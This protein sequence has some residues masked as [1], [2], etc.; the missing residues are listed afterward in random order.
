MTIKEEVCRELI[1]FKGGAI[2]QC[3]DLTLSKVGKVLDEEIKEVEQYKDEM[4]D[5]ENLTYKAM[6]IREIITNLERI[7]SKLA[8]KDEIAK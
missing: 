6:V 7:K 4:R 5:K 2:E 3:V 8:I 1:S